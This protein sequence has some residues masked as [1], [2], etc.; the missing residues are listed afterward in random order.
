MNYTE[1]LTLAILHFLAVI[2]P[3]PDFALILG[4]SLSQSKKSAFLASF[5]LGFGILFHTLLAVFGLSAVLNYSTL[6]YSVI[7]ILGGLYIIWIGLQMSGFWF[8]K[9][10]KNT[11]SSLQNNDMQNHFLKGLLTNILNPKVA[12]FFVAIFSQTVSTSTPLQFKLFYGFEMA[13]ATTIWF[14]VVANIFTN[15]SLKSTFSKYI[16]KITKFTGGAMILLGIKTIL[17]K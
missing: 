13:I 12:L 11:C 10:T 17:D 6:A 14:C 5:G 9:E 3:G 4:T 8:S 2:I 15:K 1:F 16:T 7:K